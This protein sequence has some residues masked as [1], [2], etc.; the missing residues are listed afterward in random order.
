MEPSLLTRV[1]FR[2][3]APST[4][5]LPLILRSLG[6]WEGRWNLEK[7]W[8][9]FHFSESHL[10]PVSWTSCLWNGMCVPGVLLLLLLLFKL[11]LKKKTFAVFPSFLQSLFPPH[12]PFLLF[13][14]FFFN[15]ILYFCGLFI[16]FLRISISV[17][18]LSHFTLGLA[19]EGNWVNFYAARA[20][21]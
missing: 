20:R 9:Y 4:P 8:L 1:V 3:I 12:P 11:F 2:W 15:W 18:V 6:G 17:G 19:L 14:F 16:M 5:Q 10:S 21:I 13:F 7:L